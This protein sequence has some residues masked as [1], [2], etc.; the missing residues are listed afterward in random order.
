MQ[1]R[2]TIWIALLL[3]TAA[4][5]LAIRLAPFDPSA[6]S[7]GSPFTSFL[8][9]GVRE[10]LAS[11]SMD[12]A[13][14]YFHCG[15]D[16]AV[17]EAFTGTVFQRLRDRIS[18]RAIVHREGDAIAEIL[19]W[20]WLSTQ[21]D[22]GNLDNIL[23]AAYWLHVSKHPRQ[24]ADLLARAQQRIGPNPALYLAQTRMALVL[25]QTAAANAFLT[26]GLN[27]RQADESASDTEAF[28]QTRRQLLTYRAYLCEM[29]ADTN[30]AV[31]IYRQ[32]V[33][34]HPAQCA[35]LATRADA[36]QSGAP[37]SPTAAEL[38]HAVLRVEATCSH[39]EH[40]AEHDHEHGAHREE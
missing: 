6:S 35:G 37:P 11:K 34:E 40:G 33:A 10:A 39:H 1:V 31:S 12:T 26:A 36:L 13:D 15:I 9:D 29:A 18:P 21:L 7:A 25:G 27:C 38:L 32:L 24:A 20:L 14:R 28:A 30:A 2:R 17:T 16:H 3:A 19:P 22:G 8:L 5:S 23:T 4:F